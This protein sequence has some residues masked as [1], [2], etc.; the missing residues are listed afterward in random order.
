MAAL[1]AKAVP[2]DKENIAPAIWKPTSSTNPAS[3]LKKSPE[4]PHKAMLMPAGESSD[5]QTELLKD[6]IPTSNA[7]KDEN[8][9]EDSFDYVQNLVEKEKKTRNKREKA[10]DRKKAKMSK[11][12]EKEQYFDAYD[13]VVDEAYQTGRMKPEEDRKRIADAVENGEHSQE[14]CEEMEQVDAEEDDIPQ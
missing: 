6:A 12:V 8:L 4:E 1:K 5:E 13:D 2:D 11:E 10:K 9:S 3:E 7:K 14:D